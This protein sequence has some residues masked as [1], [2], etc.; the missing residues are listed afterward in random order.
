M[1]LLQNGNP[2]LVTKPHILRFLPQILQPFLQSYLTW[3]T[4]NGREKAKFKF[5]P[6]HLPEITMV[7]SYVFKMGM[8]I[9]PAFPGCWQD[10]MAT[11]AE[12]AFNKGVNI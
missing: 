12:D 9:K 8:I 1:Q 10:D 2:K 3:C 5:Q 7:L 11:Q 6:H 4:E